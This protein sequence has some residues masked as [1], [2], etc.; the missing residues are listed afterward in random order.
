MSAQQDPIIIIVGGS[1]SL[2]FNPAMLQGSDGR[3]ANQDKQITRV[4]V[5]GDGINFAENIPN[6]IVTVKIYCDNA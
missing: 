6:G 3:F 5:T 1:V 4:E 2:E